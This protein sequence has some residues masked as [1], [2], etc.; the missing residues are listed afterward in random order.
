LG[1]LGLGVGGFQEF[2][3]LAEMMSALCLKTLAPQ[4]SGWQTD[5]ALQ[6]EQGWHMTSSSGCRD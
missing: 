1:E 3:I 6:A 4:V 2:F 5:K